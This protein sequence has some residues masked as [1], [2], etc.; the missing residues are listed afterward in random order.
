MV[1]TLYYSNGAQET[2]ENIATVHDSRK[3]IG[4]VFTDGSKLDVMRHCLIDYRMREDRADDSEV[5]VQDL[6]NRFDSFVNHFVHQVEDAVNGQTGFSV[7]MNKFDSFKKILNTRRKP[8]RT[9]EMNNLRS[10]KWR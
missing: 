6:F 7:H 2:L 1:C 8:V 5:C 10:L 9:G 4:I 3:Q